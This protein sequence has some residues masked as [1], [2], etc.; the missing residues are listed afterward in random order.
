MEFPFPDLARV[1]SSMTDE[2]QSNSLPEPPESLENPGQGSAVARPVDTK[3]RVGALD[4]LR[5]FALCGIL[6][7]NIVNFAWPGG[8]Y[9]SP[10]YPYYRLDSIGEVPDPDAQAKAIAAEEKGLSRAEKEKRREEREQEPKPQYTQGQ[11]AFCAIANPAD[12]YEWAFARLL[13]ENKMRTLF[14]MLFGA[15]VLLMTENTR[16][17]T[18]RPGWLH[19]RRMFW[20]LVIG[21][22]HAYLLWTGDILF[23][24]A[25]IGL[26][27]YPMRKLRAGTLLG[28]GLIL[29]I[30]PLALAALG[31]NVV[32]FIKEKGQAI[33]QRL[34]EQMPVPPNIEGEAPAEQAATMDDL[35]WVDAKFLSAYRALKRMSRRGPQPEM[36]TL[37]IR[38]SRNQGY[39]EGVQERFW[40]MIWAQLAE[41]FLG[42][43]ALGWP[44]VLGMGLMKL[45]FFSG[46]WESSQYGRWSLA[47][48]LLG[49]PMTWWGMMFGLQGGNSLA[50]QMRVI[51]P[52]DWV[53]SL[54]LTLANA[55]GLLWLWKT[56]RLG[57]LAGR[58][59]A[60]GQ[61]ALTNYLTQSVLCTLIFFGHGLALYGSV[62]RS[63]LAAL[64][65]GVWALQ[66]TISPWWLGRFRFGPAEWVWRS[67]T[68]WKR[69]P[70][71]LPG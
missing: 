68:Y 36:A 44:M 54:F 21:A 24:Y 14:S 32:D 70:L 59:Q 41:L 65:V 61:M 37:D 49:I 22:L 17:K 18:R 66:L 3:E 57:A 7:M 20:L 13:V 42:I 43:L 5:G 50:T 48:Y 12:Q 26:W 9:G 35:S 69:Q 4:L 10:T 33:E 31:P 62:P 28:L 34:K 39:L 46:Q 40:D 29:L 16:D 38:K 19:Y 27:L 8:A 55:S 52:L 11:L 63:G 6:L 60:A 25:S 47:L 1:I 58:L 51:L 67:L 23:A 53:G 45:G 56:G 71:V 15:G 30:T 64:V 2:N